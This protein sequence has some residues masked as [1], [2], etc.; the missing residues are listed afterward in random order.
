MLPPQFI[1]F[2]TN[3]VTKLNLGYHCCLPVVAP[4]VAVG[5]AESLEHKQLEPCTDTVIDQEC[6]RSSRDPSEEA[7]RGFAGYQLEYEQ[8]Q[9]QLLHLESCFILFEGRLGGQCR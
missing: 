4:I 1:T 6:D 8:L 3:Q 5:E 9:R 2:S 7:H